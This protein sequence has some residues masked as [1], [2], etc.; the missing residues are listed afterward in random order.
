MENE[1]TEVS[2]RLAEG[3][4]SLG[5][6]A[7]RPPRFADN[8]PGLFAGDEPT[9]LE[10]SRLR[11]RLQGPWILI[12]GFAL[13][14]FAGA[15][16]L[17]LPMAAAPGK[18]ISWS[19]AFFTST[20]A[21]TVTG[22]GVR[23]TAQDFSRIGQ[24]F[25][26]V[27]LQFGGVGFITSS[28]LLFRLIG[29]R[30]TLQTRF[31]VQQDVGSHIGSDVVRLALY[32]LTITATFEAVGAFLLWLRWRSA[33]PDSDALWFAIFQSVSSY[34]NAGFDLFGATDQGALYGFAA[35][36]YSLIVL[37][38]LIVFGGFGV[39]ILYD[40]WNVRVSR[41]LSVNTRFAVIMSVLLIVLGA[42]I[43]M[44]DP[45]LRLAAAPEM[46]WHERS[47]VS[48]FTSASARTAGVTIIPL[49]TLSETSQLSMMVLMFIG[50]AP[51][52]MAGGVSINTVAVLLTA[53]FSTT[54]GRNEAAV[55]GRRIPAES[56]G[57]AVAIMTVSTLLVTASTLLLDLI[58]PQAGIFALGF[59]VVSAFSN[60]G[61]TLNLTGKLN[62]LGRLLIAFTMFWG[63]LGPLTIVVALAQREQPL[64][65]RYPEEAV[66]L[67]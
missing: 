44:S 56:V 24:G 14:V 55:F 30:V 41:I 27:L 48:L 3:R 40:L 5:Q 31:L 12:V 34:C 38:L 22:L 10:R 16:L 9:Q 11:D 23:N 20:S 25:L 8:A 7:L 6:Q 2:D 42:A 59:E 67:G 32:V 29:R 47:A 4:S 19:D 28:V 51:A 36:W 64:L 50:A 45:Q 1:P 18:T 17:K 54:R 21:I 37:G 63:R 35:D 66:L 61:Y 62:D 15:V 57:K 33:Y 53:A 60:T 39:T 43:I 65:V 52:S 26:L 46:A 49:E 13:M 58:M